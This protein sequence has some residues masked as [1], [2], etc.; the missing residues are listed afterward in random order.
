MTNPEKLNLLLMNNIT[1]TQFAT[2]NLPATA[3]AKGL[4]IGDIGGGK[5]IAVILRINQ[6]VLDSLTATAIATNQTLAYYGDARGQFFE[7]RA[8]VNSEIIFCKDLTEVYV[9]GIGIATTVQVLIYV[10]D[11]DSGDEREVR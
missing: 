3:G 7:L 9:R 10:N 5:C 11:E 6:A 4:P 2:I 8:G 1:R